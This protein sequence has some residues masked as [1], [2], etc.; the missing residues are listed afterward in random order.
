MVVRVSHLAHIGVSVHDA[1]EAARLLANLFSAPRLAGRRAPFDKDAAGVI[2]VGMG[3]AVIRF[4][5]PST[6]AGSWHDALMRHGPTVH[7]LAFF[8][9]D[10]DTV[11]AELAEREVICLSRSTL[12]SGSFARTAVFDTRSIL[13]F[14]VELIERTADVP[15]IRPAEAIFGDVS[16]LLHIELAVDDVDAVYAWLRTVFESEKIEVEFAQFL[17]SLGYLKILHISLGNVV[18]K[19]CQPMVEGTPWDV[20]L[21]SQ[22]RIVHNITWLVPDMERTVVALEREGVKDLLSFNLDFGACVGNENV[23]DDLADQRIVDVKDRLGFHIELAE[24]F[25]R[26]LDDFIFRPFRD[27]PKIR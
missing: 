9:D 6:E 17:E 13:G 11:I 23:P 16:P 19:Y 21:K 22:G 24:K 25:A 14:N 26:N 20:L 15:A 18:L 5:E 27:W 1:A 2:D 3:D 4:V 10:F 7:S 8:V 12:P